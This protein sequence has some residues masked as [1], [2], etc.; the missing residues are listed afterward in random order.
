MRKDMAVT[1]GGGGSFLCIS[2]EEECLRLGQN[3]GQ[4]IVDFD[5]IGHAFMTI[6]QVYHL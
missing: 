6:F 1:S 3:P 4:G 5:N 2:L